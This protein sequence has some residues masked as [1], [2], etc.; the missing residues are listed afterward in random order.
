MLEAV[1]A[2]PKTAKQTV[3]L[4][5][6]TQHW[7]TVR[8][9]IVDARIA[10]PENGVLHDGQPSSNQLSVA[11][12]LASID[13][14]MICIWIHHLVIGPDAKSSQVPKIGTHV[15]AIWRVDDDWMGVKSWRP[16]EQAHLVAGW[17]DV[18]RN[19]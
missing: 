18:D 19:A 13:A 4:R 12:G 5:K 11:N 7:L 17:L 8:G 6:P 3:V 16:T 1:P 2:P 14:L 10:S 15:S 9:S